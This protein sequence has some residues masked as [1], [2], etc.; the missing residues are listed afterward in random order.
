[1]PCLICCADQEAESANARLGKIGEVRKTI[2]PRGIT[3]RSK[4]LTTQ[5]HGTCLSVP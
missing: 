1:V 3:M 2:D 4:S 5:L